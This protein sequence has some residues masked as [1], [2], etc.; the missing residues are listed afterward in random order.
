MNILFTGLPGSG[1]STISEI[2]S[3]SINKELIDIDSIIIKD[4]KMDLQ[5]YIDTFGN[6]KFKEKERA[7]IL[8]IINNANN[9]I[10]SPPGSIIYY[11]DIM[12]LIMDKD[13]FVVVYLEC[14]LK[15]IL[16]R[17]NNFYNRGVVLDK[18]A[19]DPFD[20]LYKE[21]VP[22]YEKYFNYKINTNQNLDLVLQYI[23]NLNI[24]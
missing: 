14:D 21:R 13:N 2:V 1:K 6:D 24:F 22:L 12:E 5:K 23:K 7:I 18:N 15:R 20:K 11:K 10:I 4:I 17:T 19:E 8:N 3:K 16:K 9:T